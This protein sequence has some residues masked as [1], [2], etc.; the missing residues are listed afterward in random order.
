MSNNSYYLALCLQ[1]QVAF[2]TDSKGRY[3]PETLYQWQQYVRVYRIHDNELISKMKKNM[4]GTLPDKDIDHIQAVI[5]DMTYGKSK[6]DAY[7]LV[8]SGDFVDL[9][10][11]D[12]KNV[13][14]ITNT[15]DDCME[16]GEI[17][18]IKN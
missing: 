5:D 1:F 18:E 14:I 8:N 9:S 17:Q 16:P 7:E 6:Q 12:S 15:C 2:S 13:V 10:N 3:L 4:S 11:I